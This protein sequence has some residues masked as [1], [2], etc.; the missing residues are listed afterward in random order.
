[1]KKKSKYLMLIVFLLSLVV[2]ITVKADSGFDTNWD[3]GGS[4]SGG[5][6]WNT[7]NSWGESNFY[8][9]FNGSLSSITVIIIVVIAVIIV[10]FLFKTKLND[11]NIKLNYSEID[12]ETIKKIIPKFNKAKFYIL[13]F[14]IYKNVQNAWMNFDEKELRNFVTDEMFNMYLAQ[15]DTM[16]I[17][18]EKNIISD[19]VLNE[20]KITDV[21]NNN[22]V[23]SIQAYLDISMYD[24][25]I[26][27]ETKK[28]KRGT[29]SQ[30]VNINY[31]ITFVK[32]SKTVKSKKIKCPNC[33]AEIKMN[34]SGKCEYCECNIV[35]NSNSYV[36]SKKQNISQK[37]D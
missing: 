17:K 36:M 3:S 22:G 9:S 26:D 11:S 4:W 18:N 13:A 24:Y 20:I 2:M 19:V 10:A 29:Q 35:V 21:N 1:M 27:I 12:D 33:G 32:S 34:A 23:I 31:L 15:M 16:K 7:D 6:S 30:K 25:L 8:S 28:V 14:E 5:N 37:V